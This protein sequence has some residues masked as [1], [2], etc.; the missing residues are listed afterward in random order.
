MALAELMRLRDSSSRCQLFSIASAAAASAA[1]HW[2]CNASTW[3][4]IDASPGRV[5]PSGCGCGPTGES[6]ICTAYGG[7]EDVTRD[8]SPGVARKRREHDAG[9]CPESSWRARRV[10]PLITVRHC[11][12]GFA[13]LGRD[14]L[15]W[16]ACRRHPP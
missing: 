10:A 1:S 6:L 16:T 8:F 14:G 11:H 7:P 5:A 3:C 15:A 2:R 12:D 4:L 9:A 13:D